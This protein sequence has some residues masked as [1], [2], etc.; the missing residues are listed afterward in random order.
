MHFKRGY[1]LTGLG[2]EKLEQAISIEEKISQEQVSLNAGLDR[3]TVSKALQAEKPVNLR[4][5]R[6]IFASLRISLE[7]RDYYRVSTQEGIMSK[8]SDKALLIN[9]AKMLEDQAKEKS[10]QAKRESDK[11]KKEELLKKVEEILNQAKELRERART[12]PDR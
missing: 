2:L 12:A 8:E 7:D 3:S 11:A 1:V 9:S 4:T 5:I 10:N 6:R